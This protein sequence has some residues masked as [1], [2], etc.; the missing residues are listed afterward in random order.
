MACSPSCSSKGTNPRTTNP[1]R[2]AGR[3]APRRAP[4]PVIKAPPRQL[5]PWAARTQVF[6]RAVGAPPS[7]GRTSSTTS[8]GSHDL[9]D[10]L[11]ASVAVTPSEPSQSAFSRA[12]HAYTTALRD[13]P[14]ATKAVT[15]FLGFGIGDAIAQSIG[16]PFDITRNIRMSLYGLILDGPLGHK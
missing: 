6:R 15:S 1:Q 7:P 3:K 14:T 8:L 16:A 4:A 9:P 11:A 13:H 10:A 12:L 5:A 2:N